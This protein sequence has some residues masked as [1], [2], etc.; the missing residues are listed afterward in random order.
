MCVYTFA[1][2]GLVWVPNFFSPHL[3]SPTPSLVLSFAVVAPFKKSKKKNN[4]KTPNRNCVCSSSRRPCVCPSLTPHLLT[5]IPGHCSAAK[6]SAVSGPAAGVRHGGH[7]L[8]GGSRPGRLWRRCCSSR[9]AGT[10]RLRHRGWVSYIHSK[11]HPSK[12]KSDVIITNSYNMLPV[13]IIIE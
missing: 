7:H 9:P 3:L 2:P 13:G 11:I 12:L 10:R 8:H 1:Y 5:I 4:I 6:D